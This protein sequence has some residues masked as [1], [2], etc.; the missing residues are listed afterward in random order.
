MSI[1]DG[2]WVRFG[3]GILVLEFILI[4]S[5]AFVATIGT[6]KET[7]TFNRFKVFAGLFAFYGLFA[8]AMALAFKSWTLFIIYSAVML[9]RWQGLLTHPHEAKEE[10]MKRSGLGALFY[11]LATF[12]SIFIPWP[13]LGITTSVLNE[14]YSDRGGGHWEAHPEAALA[15]GVIYFTLVGITELNLAWQGQKKQSLHKADSRA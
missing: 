15:A 3:V 14:V 8:G 2:H 11:L 7:S 1:D 6:D 10:A 5:G 9:S 4:H 12:L 13:T